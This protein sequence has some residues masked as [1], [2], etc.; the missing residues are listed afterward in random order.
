MWLAPV[1][2]P[3]DAFTVH[4]IESPIGV[5]KT[6]LGALVYASGRGPRLNEPIDHQAAPVRAFHGG[7]HNE[8]ALDMHHQWF[9]RSVRISEIGTFKRAV[10]PLL[11]D[12]IA[13]PGD[14]FL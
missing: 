1:R 8:A 2:Q 12:R 7:T 14:T 11:R 4:F 9:A 10:I 3:L 6:A 5:D 13:A